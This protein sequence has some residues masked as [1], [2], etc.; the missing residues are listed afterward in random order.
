MIVRDLIIFCLRL[1]SHHRLNWKQLTLTF[2]CVF[3]CVFRTTF[4]SRA[5]CRALCDSCVEQFV[6]SMSISYS[7]KADT[8]ANRAQYQRADVC[9]VLPARTIASQTNCPPSKPNQPSEVW[10]KEQPKSNN[11]LGIK[12]RTSCESLARRI[13][14]FAPSQQFKVTV[15]G[16]FDRQGLEDAM[17]RDIPGFD[18]FIDFN[19]DNDSTE[20][21][22]R[23][24]T[25][26]RL[27]CKALRARQ[28]PLCLLNS[29]TRPRT[30]LL[31]T[32]MS[33]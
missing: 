5:S 1:V 13:V 26:A 23:K 33:A 30:K 10:W 7:T 28:I 4:G 3:V 16:S 9:G 8:V 32:K 27:L 17:Q 25:T 14:L 11:I 20:G 24:Q 15:A 6:S 12:P 19:G 2:H 18:N 21:I 29:R 22:V 31:T